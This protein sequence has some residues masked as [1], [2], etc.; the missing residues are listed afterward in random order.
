MT[1]DGNA[2]IVERHGKISQRVHRVSL[3]SEPW[4]IWAWSKWFVIVQRSS[5]L[6]PAL[7]K[8]P[9]ERHGSPGSQL[10]NARLS[11]NYSH[12]QPQSRSAGGT[13]HFVGSFSAPCQDIS[14]FPAARPKPS[15]NSTQVIV[16]YTWPPGPQHHKQQFVSSNYLKPSTAEPTDCP[17]LSWSLSSSQLLPPFC[18]ATMYESD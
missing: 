1:E 18:L 6:V 16:N 12:S 3:E 15:T 14:N 7:H 11:H 2:C 10:M 8:R 5:A 4:H 13:T 17:G 9:P